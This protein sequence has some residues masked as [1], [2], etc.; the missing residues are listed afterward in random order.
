[1][2]SRRSLLRRIGR[3]E[4]ELAELRR[5]AL[6]VEEPAP[7][8]PFLNV[9]AGVE[10]RVADAAGEKGQFLMSQGSGAEPR[11]ENPYRLGYDYD[12]PVEIPA[13]DYTQDYLYVAGPEYADIDFKRSIPSGGS[14]KFRTPIYL[15]S[16]HY[17]LHEYCRLAVYHYTP[18]LSVL[19][20]GYYL[21]KPGTLY[22]SSGGTVPRVMSV[23]LTNLDFAALPGDRATRLQ[24][25][26][27]TLAYGVMRQSHPT[28]SNK[29]LISQGASVVKGGA[30]ARNTI[31]NTTGYA[32]TYTAISTEERE[33][34]QIGLESEFT[35]ALVALNLEIVYN[36]G[37]VRFS[38][39]DSTIPDWVEIKTVLSTDT[40]NKGFGCWTKPNI[41]T[42]YL[43]VTAW[44]DGT[45]YTRVRIYK[46]YAWAA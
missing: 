24:V 4:R 27:Y 19:T 6:L 22:Y 41:K 34:Y 37:G 33:V 36:F 32:A 15:V 42:Q 5:R 45:N 31:D 11:W 44:G 2:S 30:S 26:T 17:E 7:N 20:P 43:R 25:Q 9:P 39:Y 16:L 13:L 38:Y 18:E 1:L 8:D 35:L 23:D 40:P 14:A 29:A 12:P 10:L 46:L 21:L 28:Y 3:L